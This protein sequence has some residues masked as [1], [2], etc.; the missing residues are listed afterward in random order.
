MSLTPTKAMKLGSELHKILI[1][2]T[3]GRFTNQEFIVAVAALA[4][5]VHNKAIA[6]ALDELHL[7]RDFSTA[8]AAMLKLKV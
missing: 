4:Q 8:K 6:A 1:V 7:A 5:A 3:G 2:N